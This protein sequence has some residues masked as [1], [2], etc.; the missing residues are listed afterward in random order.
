MEPKLREITTKYHTFVENQ[1]LTE[2]QLN[3]FVTYFDDQDRLSRVFLHGVG[4]VCGFKVS[5]SGAKI[6]ISQGVGLTTDGDLVQLQKDIEKSPLKE[7]IT[8][9]VSYSHYRKFKDDTARYERF[10]K[11]TGSG[12]ELT[13][14]VIDLYELHP[15]AVKNS[16]PLNA[17]P[18]L[19]T[20]VVL[21]YLESFADDGDLCTA[22]DCDN[23]GIANVNRL[24]VLL[25]SEADARY[26]ASND[27]IYSEH[28]RFEHY[29]N[30]PTPA[31]KRV[32]LNA[33]NTTKYEELKRA[34]Y[35]AVKNDN[36]VGELVDGINLLVRNFGGLLQYKISDAALNSALAKLKSYFSF[37]AYNVPF[38]IQYR[39]DFLKDMVDTYDEVKELLLDLRQICLP[40]IT[41]FPKHLMLGMLSEIN[42]EPKDLRH[43]FYAS[44]ASGC[45]GKQMD[46]ARSLLHKI[47]ALIDSYNAK[48]EGIRLTPSKK[49]PALS[50]RSIPFYYNIG[51]DF[52]KNWDFAKTKL[53][54][55]KFNV[56]YRREKLSAAPQIQ[57]PL[58]YNTDQFD[59]YRIEGHQGKDY[60]DALEELDDLKR[61]YGL[62][63][64]V[65]ALSVNIKTDDLNIDDYECEFEDL[66]V[67]L[68][69]WTKEQ[70]CILAEVAAFFS[71]FSTKIPGANVKEA[72][73]DL[74]QPMELDTAVNANSNIR[75]D[76]NIATNFTGTMYQPAYFKT[77]LGTATKKLYEEV[78]K[79]KVVEDNMSTVEDTVGVEMRKAITET[80]GGSVNDIIANAEKKL[81]VKVNTEE[82]NAEPALKDF[83]VNKGVELMA[84]T[85]VLT[86]RMPVAVTLVDVTRVND[87]K[88]SLSQL[89][90]LVKKLKA[91][92]QSTK[93]SVG[94]QAFTG[95]LINQLSSVCCSGKKLEVL[96]D[97]VN[98]RKEQILV[99]LQLSK[100]IEQ[101]PGLEHKAGVEPGGTFVLVYKNS[102]KTE[103][104]INNRIEKP[105]GKQILDTGEIARSKSLLSDKILNLDKLSSPERNLVLK[106]ATELLR[107]EDLSSRFRDLAALERIIPVSQIPDNTVVADFALPYMCCSDCAPVN[108]II[109]KPPA[110]LRLSHDKYCLLTDTDPV[111][112]EVT[113]ADGEIG[114][115]P[116]VAGLN[117]SNGKITI[118]ADNFPGTMLGQAIH[119]TVDNQVTDA[120]LTV[121]KGIQADFNVPAEPTDQ[122]T[123]R[124][125]PTGDLEGATFFWEF[126]DGT[127]STEQNPSH[128]YK[129]PVND[130]N[131]VAV[132]LTVTAANR[133]CKTSVEHT[134]QFAELQPEI[135]LEKDAFCA[136]DKNEY[137]FVVTPANSRV[138]ITGE[139][140]IRNNAGGYSFIPAAAKTGSLTFSLNGEDSGITVTLHAAPQAVIS[141]KQ[142]GN[143][144]I[145]SND[146]KNAQTFEWVINGAKR[147][148]IN[149][150]PV[151]INLKPD[152]PTEWKIELAARGADVCPA[153]KATTLIATKYVEETPVNTCVEE[154]TAA[155]LNDLKVLSAIKADIRLINDLVLRT[156]RIYGGTADFNKGVID[157]IDA[158]LGGKAND[159]LEAMLAKLLQD[160][161]MMIAETA[162]L[163]EQQ[164]QILTLFELQLRLLY[165]VLGCQSNDAIKAF[166]DLINGLLNQIIE[167][168]KMLKEHGIIF[169]DAMK[170]FIGAYA[171]K[172]SD[173]ILLADH[174][175]I[176]T[177]NKLI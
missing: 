96:L 20:M 92:Y 75:P 144:L 49:L 72:E 165:N 158:F 87:Y 47:F 91:R 3:E 142:T 29:F 162:N 44:A 160:T 58:Y 175:K 11:V 69:A 50:Q 133:I 38:D 76:I 128:T 68:K 55:E 23:Q 19:N 168:L 13:S 152:S 79:G 156:R 12:E 14:E 67:M 141:A 8:G 166:G 135:A 117:I 138:E 52:L 66:K 71:S 73:L 62:S 84:H 171:K 18:N 85:Y 41:A 114:M 110:S 88:L 140:V 94:L 59:F 25:V 61:K 106:S 17:F 31:V 103:E 22:I 57:D 148:T 134:I 86:Q 34:Y 5:R 177:G 89:C 95:L 169:S 37:S 150:D 108:Y 149:L 74:K 97:E 151:V 10:R 153:D 173:R 28:D 176:V 125:V 143:Q 121:Y 116:E 105:A 48:S 80:K 40:D 163:P 54:R 24:R 145:I 157:R 112:Y 104:S 172:V 98:T 122:A 113:P 2:E 129:L 118:T 32:V 164:K 77:A 120:V 6:S 139:G 167:L 174:M 7:L 130:E 81:E 1:V 35:D 100:F 161:A 33:I 147:Q 131:K 64:D 111:L 4:V 136:N 78:E 99:R 154:T 170:K 15:Q 115:N 60:R 83:V 119:F 53:F 155:I 21:L 109:S 36:T 51:T 45:D 126:G 127:T 90:S 56:G 123:Q 107:Y 65:K 39:Y 26:I 30:L 93:L 101:H 146:S 137:P 43:N 70:D 42:S 82:W 102:E 159:Q 46:R 16:K 9:S 132:R 63:F 27:L 124:F